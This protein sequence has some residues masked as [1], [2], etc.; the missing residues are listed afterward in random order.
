MF[1]DQTSLLLALGFAAFAL[2]TT[3]FVTWLSARSER[4]ILMWATGAAVMVLAFAGFSIYA[5]TS[6]YLLLWISNMLLTGS[7]VI[8]YGA[9]CVFTEKHMPQGRV[10]LVGSLV[11]TAITVPFIMGF[12]ALG[13]MIGN[14][15]NAT[16]LATTAKK[17][18]DGRDEA[19]LWVGG[20][21]GL[22][23][24]TALSFIP[25]ALVIYLKGP[26]VLTAPPSG[27]AE[28]LNSIVGLIGLT[29]IG[30]LS[31]ALNQARV[32]RRHQHA[33]N[34]DDL[35]GLLNRR[36][37]FERFA[38]NNMETTTAAV[39]FDL[40][41]FKLINDR[42]GH[43][44]GDEAL[45]RFANLLRQQ[46]PPGASA[47]RIGGEEFIVIW[48]LTDGA[49]AL[50]LAEAIRASFALELVQGPAGAFHGTVSA[51]MAL[52]LGLSDS[53]EA[54]MRRADDALYAAK[55]G[56]RNRVVTHD[57]GLGSAS[58]IV[59]KPSA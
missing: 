8:F 38:S 57:T 7:F 19:P 33:A 20:I 48:P 6:I 16:V 42:H 47:A 34:T 37:V 30:A 15:A 27:W 12:D 11:A 43:A 35:T 1:V 45:K 23:S 49:R 55:H 31:L 56:G 51:G 39:I 29:G 25:C 10:T 41:H 52:G 13:A 4:F 46:T 17:F 18:W 50:A 9:G 28:D 54:T 44:A 53:F 14:L 3:L 36:A 40:D 2:A 59:R 22:Y 32:A 58:P 5:V 24:L 26:L 21:V